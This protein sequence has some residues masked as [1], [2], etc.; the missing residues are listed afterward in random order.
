MLRYMARY[1]QSPDAIWFLVLGLVKSNCYPNSLCD[2]FRNP[3]FGFGFG[4]RFPS[5]G[6]YVNHIQLLK[7]PWGQGRYRAKLAWAESGSEAV[8]SKRAYDSHSGKGHTEFILLK[9]LRGSQLWNFNNKTQEIGSEPHTDNLK[10]VC[11]NFCK[12]LRGPQGPGPD[13]I[14]SCAPKLSRDRPMVP[15]EANDAES[16]ALQR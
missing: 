11:N 13:S 9:N 1:R 8:V 16:R 5:L 15:Q 14:F 4:F 2:L 3:R 12:V 7:H 6:A 10:R